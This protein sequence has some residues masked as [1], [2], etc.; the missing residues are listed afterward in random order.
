MSNKP[1]VGGNGEYKGFEEKVAL[2]NELKKL[3]DKVKSRMPDGVSFKLQ[4]HK[5]LYLQFKSPITGERVPRDADL[6]YDESGIYQ[7][8]DKAWKIKEALGRFKVASEF[9][10][11]YKTEILGENEIKNDLKTY[12]EIITEIE[13]EFFNGYNIHTKRSRSRDIPNDCKTWKY[14]KLCCL[15]KISNWDEYPTISG[16]KTALFS[17]KQGTNSFKRAY[18]E[19]RT[20]ASKAANSRDLLE[21]FSTIDPEQTQ[22]KE[23]GS[24]SWKEFLDWRE[25]MLAKKLTKSDVKLARKKWLWV[26]SM[27]ILYALRPS[28]IA[29]AI[30]LYEPYTEKGVTIPAI[31]D[32]ENKDLLLVINDFS[33]VGVSTKTGKRV[34]KP[35]NTNPE[36]IEFLA[37]RDIA[38]HEY[39]P[40][41][42]SLPETICKG[43]NTSHRTYLVN[44][45]FPTTETY[46]LRHLGNQLGEQYGIPQEIRARSMGHSVEQ[47][48]RTY[49]KRSNIQTTVDILTNHSRQPISLELAK[50]QLEQ[51]GILNDESVQLALKVIYQLD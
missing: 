18:Y 49:K 51:L 37:I 3:R 28:E 35:V 2:T 6:P 10:E 26:T 34:C 50:S 29:A 4:G 15:K 36:I 19:L 47:N 7:G 21:W 14:G 27:C 39:K 5:Y 17:Y 33:P 38:L 32:P 9:E 48:D 41:K 1:P 22:Y 45:D 31:N 12:R 24:I 25:M 44:H 42:G 46:A 16:L 40:R 43:F 30:N 20:V 8:I 13:E 11:W 23:K